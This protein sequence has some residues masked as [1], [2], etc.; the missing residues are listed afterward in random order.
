MQI[1][2]VPV[3]LSAL[4]VL[5]VASGAVLVV[6][7]LPDAAATTG[8]ALEVLVAGAGLVLAW[9]I[10]VKAPRNPVPLALA[11]IAALATA[12]PAVEDWGASADT[13]DPWPGAD[14][15]SPL[16]QAIWPLQLVGFGLLLLTFPAAPLGRR[17]AR[18]VLVAG[19][20]GTVLI[21][22]GNWGTR[23]DAE[24]TGWRV[25]VAITG[26][27][28]LVTAL[29]LATVDLVRRSRR[30]GAAERAQA[31]WLLLATGCVL[32]LM[33]L[34]WLTVPDV[35]PP[36][37]GYASFLVTLYVL[38]PT[39]VAV[40][41]IRYDLFDIERLLSDTVAVVAT[42]AVAAVVWA[43]SVVLVHEAVRDAAGLETGAAAFL[44]ALALVPTY[45]RAHR[46]S[47]ATF[48]RER[49]VLLAAVRAFAADVHQGVREPEDVQEVLREV[50]RDPGL[51]VGLAVPGQ[52]RLVDPS[53]R[54]TDLRAD[55]VLRAGSARIGVVELGR[56]SARRRR[57][58]QEAARHCWSAF[59]S[60]RLRAGLRVA[61]EEVE[62]SR[63]RLNVAASTER[64]KLE[65]D[66]HDGAQQALVAIGMRLRSA[67]AGLATDT[68]EHADIETA[69][70]Q[71]AGTVEELRRISQGVRPS[72]LDDG[73]G[74]AL[75]VLR[76]SSPVPLVLRVD[77]QVNRDG[78]DETVAQAAYY[79]VA[80]AVA[81]A[82]KHAHATEVV[83]EIAVRDGRLAIV[84]R[85][86]GI[87]GVNPEHTPTALRDRVDP[88]GGSIT[89]TS[90][91][92]VGTT[93]EAV[94]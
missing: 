21:L 60:A 1:R 77:E 8:T 74:P 46:W 14:I 42:S 86:D 9:L 50:L 47:G 56:V 28:L 89:V 5:A 34:S 22:I 83:V 29:L 54:A 55:V 25:P 90:P 88:L 76:D 6:A 13:T 16:V 2:P 15:A 20:A 36:E 72:R 45:R 84:V 64:R 32:V 62:A 68:A 3:T 53:G 79:V 69:I 71:L 65:R 18:R 51:R 94:L 57:L 11:T 49:T 23:A 12:T 58:A 87:G 48:D 85:D 30:T 7:E 26:L 59:E 41:V 39:A 73:L 80:E 10:A 81:N 38:V 52:P 24:F 35:V 93:I 92:G 82:L 67:Q 66:L 78:L 44:T 4:T 17:F 40:A 75:E 61:L 70:T 91:S 31:R 37:V 27:A 33:V 63:E 43:A 19:G